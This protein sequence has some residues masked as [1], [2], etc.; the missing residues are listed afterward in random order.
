MRD[1]EKLYVTEQALCFNNNNC[2]LSNSWTYKLI[3]YLFPFL[4]GTHD[5]L[6]LLITSSS[7]HRKYQFLIHSMLFFKQS[8]TWIKIDKHNAN[9]DADTERIEE[10]LL[11]REK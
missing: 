4:C 8:H 2:A 9:N 3:Y 6:P 7:E 5:F 11:Y 1:Y 10:K